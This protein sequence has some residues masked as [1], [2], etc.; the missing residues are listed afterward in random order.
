VVPAESKSHAVVFA[1]LLSWLPMMPCR[2]HLHA[3]RGLISSAGNKEGVLGTLWARWLA[4][5]LT[6]QQAQQHAAGGSITNETGGSGGPPNAAGDQPHHG[7]AQ[8]GDSH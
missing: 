6:G 1:L 2:A 4:G 3:A 8:G 7:P 5:W